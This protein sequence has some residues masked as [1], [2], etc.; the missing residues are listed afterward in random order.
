[1]RWVGNVYMSKIFFLKLINFF[2][3]LFLS[4][5][6]QQKRVNK[7]LIINYLLLKHTILEHEAFGMSQVFKFWQHQFPEMS[8]SSF[9]P[10]DDS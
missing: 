6:I 3:D 8:N 10:Q 5:C 2:V 1:M 4:V 7:L 9:G